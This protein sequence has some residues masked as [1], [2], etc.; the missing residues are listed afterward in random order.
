MASVWALIPSFRWLHLQNRC[1]LPTVTFRRD[2]LFVDN[3]WGLNGIYT[4]PDSFI[5]TI[6]SLPC[7]SYFS[8]GTCEVILDKRCFIF[9]WTF[10]I[11]TAAVIALLA[12]RSTMTVATASVTT[13]TR[14]PYTSFV[15][16]VE[17]AAHRARYLQNLSWSW[18]RITLIVE[19]WLRI[20]T[21]AV[22]RSDTLTTM[23]TRSWLLN[24]NER[25]L[26][27]F[28]SSRPACRW[29]NGRR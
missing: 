16:I 11:V 26:A 18:K 20:F 17:M 21:P 29:E 5:T 13:F 7:F 1:K 6:W 23:A 19:S 14:C 12:T 28:L 25:L 2:Q 24:S 10:A 27:F 15:Y 22:K 3:F 8:E 4:W 9:W